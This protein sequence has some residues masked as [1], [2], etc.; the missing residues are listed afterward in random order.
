MSGVMGGVEKKTWL[1]IVAGVLTVLVR[2][3][4]A[5]GKLPTFPFRE[6]INTNFALKS[7]AFVHNF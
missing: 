2:G 1:E 5:V 6:N 4:T 7:P 3:W